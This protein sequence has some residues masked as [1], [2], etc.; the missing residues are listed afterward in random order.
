MQTTCPNFHIIFKKY[1][2]IIECYYYIWNHHGKCIQTSTN[3]P[4]I[5]L[6]IRDIFFEKID[7]FAKIFVKLMAA[8]Y[9]LTRHPDAASISFLPGCIKRCHHYLAI[10]YTIILR[11]RRCPGPVFY[12]YQNR[13]MAFHNSFSID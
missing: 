1:T 2:N 3:M 6:A 10:S 9:V 7:Q 8:C 11:Y 12:S 5:G 13:R 4:G